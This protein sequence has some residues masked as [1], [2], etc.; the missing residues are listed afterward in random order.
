VSFFDIGLSFNNENKSTFEFFVKLEKE[1][2][3]F[4]LST[5]ICVETSRLS[6]NN[7]KLSLILESLLLSSEIEF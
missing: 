6:N 7:P 5:V 3:G 1:P 4:D 2:K